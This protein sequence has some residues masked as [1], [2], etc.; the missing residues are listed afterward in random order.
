MSRRPRL[1]ESHEGFP[2][3][4][5]FIL[6]VATTSLF[7]I[8]T[9]TAALAQTENTTDIIG[10]AEAFCT[11]PDSWQVASTTNTV[12]SSQFNGHV[13]T[14]PDNLIATTAGNAVVSTAE[15]AIR[16][17]GEASCNTTHTITLTSQNGGLAAT[18]S[19]PPPGFTRLRRMRYDAQWRD[20]NWGIFNWVPNAPGDSTTYNHGARVPPGHH[21][22]DIRLGLLRDPTNSPMVAGEYT[23]QLT[24]TVSVPS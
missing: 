6:A 16:I 12:S 13:W 1:S 3:M 24:V 4:K 19:N 23:D 22:F 8:A 9:P 17:R 10:T 5:K 2:I 20:T 14:I 7:A 21:D 18:V 11:L 15:V